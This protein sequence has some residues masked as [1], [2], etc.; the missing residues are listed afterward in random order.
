MTKVVIIGGGA[1]GLTAAINAKSDT[2]EVV[3]LER[4][5]TCG[6][7]L[8]ITGNGRCNYYN[9][10]QNLEKYYSQN[11]ELIPQIINDNNSK[12]IIDFFDDLGIVPMIKNGYYYPFSNQAITIKNSLE[13]EALRKKVVI[14]NNFLV[15]SIKK[16]KN[17][18]IISSQSDQIIADIL[19]I[20]TGSKAS[21]LTGSDGIGYKL[22]KDLSHNI[23]KPLPALVQLKTKGKY[24]K[25]WSGIRTEVKLSLYEDGK[26]IKEEFGQ[27]Q[28]TNYGIS[29]ICTFNL[30]GIIS[31]GLNDHK[32]EIVKI[33]FLPFLN[34]NSIDE[35]IDWF[36]S[37]SI[38]KDKSIFDILEGVLNNKLVF[39][40]LKYNNIEKDKVWYSL[41]QKEKIKLITSLISFKVE[42][43]ET[44]GFSN[45]QVCSG[46]V[47]LTDINLTTMES[48]INKNL[49]IVGELLDIY[50]DCG[51][52]NLTIAW[53]SSILA[54]Q[55]IK[56]KNND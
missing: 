32:E 6:K 26:K 52:Y 38:K 41:S 30:S 50:G 23:V 17:K 10:N 28:L 13:K 11:M 31:R 42:I 53:L 48:K 27:I 12:K 44:T 8:L 18:Y 21:P 55:N 9:S 2:N 39:V 20:A 36:N 45:A 7:K 35:Y 40:L 4:N 49:Y 43:T 14:K 16:E 24:L 34:Y 37:K 56:E 33:N 25:D 5:S 46:G 1:A 19:V 54:G 51:G 47:L 3:I 15:E 22:L 29:G